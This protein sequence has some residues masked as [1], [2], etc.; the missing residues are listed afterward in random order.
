[1]SLLRPRLVLLFLAL[2]V[3]A[4]CEAQ[5]LERNTPGEFDYYVLVLG[6]APSYCLTEGELRRDAECNTAKPHAFAG[7]GRNT[8][9]AG[10]RTAL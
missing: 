8:R 1:M 7:Y 6:W 10:P 2:L 9:R 4:S 5:A 3:G